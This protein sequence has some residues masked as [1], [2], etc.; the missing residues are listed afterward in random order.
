M[1]TFSLYQTVWVPS[2][3]GDFT[4]VCATVILSTVAYN[5]R[6]T[7]RVQYC[8]TQTWTEGERPGPLPPPK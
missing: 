2:K 4:P 6:N 1:S 3:N 7:N 8:C 5:Y